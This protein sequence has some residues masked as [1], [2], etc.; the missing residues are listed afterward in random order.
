MF[1]YMQARNIPGSYMPTTDYLASPTGSQIT[2]AELNEM[3][4][5]GWTIVPHQTIGTAL[6]A[7]SEA[8]MRA[9][10]DEVLAVHASYGWTFKD[11]FYPSGGA[12]NDL[13][14]QVMASYGIRYGNNINTGNLQ[15]SQP[16]YGGTINPYR[17]WSYTADG[18]TASEVATAINHAI[19]YGGG[20]GILWH[21]GDG[22]D[23][24]PFKASMNL[25]FR[26]R[27]ANVIDLVN[28]DTFF[29]RFSNPRKAR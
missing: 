15:K 7:M 2:V 24:G 9:E 8:E 27:E 13:S 12:G 20:L 18:K 5:A 22:A 26:L 4:A 17:L 1:P 10:I 14:R 21:D 29:K 25:L 6:T 3:K 16:L 23:E 28:Y 11:F 19:K